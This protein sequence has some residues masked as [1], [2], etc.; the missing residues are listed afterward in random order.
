MLQPLELLVDDDVTSFAGDALGA[1]QLLPVPAHD[2]LRPLVQLVLRQREGQLQQELLVY[3]LQVVE[4]HS[5]RVD[6]DPQDVVDGMETFL[7]AK[8]VE[9]L[10]ETQRGTTGGLA[11][12]P[13]THRLETCAKL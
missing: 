6:D 13:R 5:L 12:V 4:G 3:G 9:E 8:L 10:A 11:V 7:E 2:Q 1:Q